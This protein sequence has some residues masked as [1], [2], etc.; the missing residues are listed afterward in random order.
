M[1]PTS[2]SPPTA[3]P[4]ATWTRSSE[5]EWDKVVLDEAQA[6]KN[7]ASET[8]QQ[9]RAAPGPQPGRPHRH[10]DRERPRRPVGDHG[11]HQPGPG[12]YRGRLHRPAV[13]SRATGD[14]SGPRRAL[15]ALNGIL[16]FRR[17][18][19]EPAIAAELPDRIDELD[20]CAMTPEQIGLYQ[21]VLD[22]L[23][24]ETADADDTPQKQGRR[25]GRHHGAEADLQPPG[26]YQA[27]DRPLDGRS[28]KLARLNEIV[29][30]GVR[31]RRA[32]ADLHPLRLLGREAGR[33]PHRAHRHRHRL[34]PRRPGPDGA[35]PAGRGLPGREG[36]G[37]HG[38]LAEGGRHG[39][40]PDR[41][42]P[43]RALRPLVEPGGRGPGPGPGL[44]DRPDQ[45]GHL[46][47]AGLPRHGRRAGRRG[48]GRQAPDRRH[49]AAEVELD[50]RSRR[51]TA[52]G[53]A[54]HRCRCDPGRGRHRLVEIL[55]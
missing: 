7:P 35:G 53:G 12:R 10:P 47:P 25:P 49:G 32:G 26:D 20:H 4:C 28:G 14:G 34:L 2:S 55:S 24:V 3:P 6:I 30:I 42:Q 5:V 40:Q 16:V 36:P 27:D 50:R 18:K 31:R 45:H 9:L 44:A 22:D 8:A 41:G 19:A 37:R 17:T 11:L 29:D 48:G 54:R 43:R 38:A 33:L 13:A 51:R 23:V 1:T 39:S 21:A 52:A 46:P 15:R